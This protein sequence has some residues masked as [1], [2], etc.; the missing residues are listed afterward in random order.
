MAKKNKIRE[1]DLQSFVQFL[2]NNKT[3]THKQ[4]KQ[5]DSLL[6]RDIV[7]EIKVADWSGKEGNDKTFTP[8][9]PLSTAQFLSKFNDPMG[10]K[11]L[12]H[13]F[14]ADDGARPY[15]MPAFLQQLKNVMD[16]NTSTLPKSLW[17]LL[18]KFIKDG[19]WID[20]YGNPHKSFFSD[21]AWVSWSEANRMHP[22]NNPD[23]RDE[24]MTFR[25]TIRVVPPLLQEI[26]D[27]VKGEPA[28]NLNIQ[29]DGKLRK[30]DFYTN[31]Y[32]LYLAISRIINMMNARAADYPDVLVAFKR[33]TDKEGRMQR[34]IVITQ[35]GSFSYK[36]LDDVRDRLARNPDA[37]DIG[38]IRNWLNGYCFW[39]VSSIWDGVPSKWNVLRQGEDEEVEALTGD[40]AG[41]THELT[42][43]LV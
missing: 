27:K 34:K 10:L 28:L 26:V 18:K 20:T 35:K 19:G 16:G 24:V 3:L 2:T 7:G 12:T 9:S 33:Q 4:K 5:R 23:F 14:D 39:S 30:A 8:I 38:S 43:Y 29:T 15:T 21:N 22:I 41:F 37:G 25:S 32:F 31:T 42:F 11:Y 17:T 1:Q 40:V 6:A 13:D 36:S